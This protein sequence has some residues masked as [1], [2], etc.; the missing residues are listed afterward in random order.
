MNEKV[1]KRLG[2]DTD[3]LREMGERIVEIG[4]VIEE[5]TADAREINRLCGGGYDALEGDGARAVL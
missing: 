4:D 1:L 2:I 5:A 3:E